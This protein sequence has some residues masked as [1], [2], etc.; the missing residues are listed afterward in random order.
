MSSYHRRSFLKT[1]LGFL[2]LSL[3]NPP[4]FLSAAAATNNSSRH[5]FDLLPQADETTG[6]HLL[7]LP[8]GFRYRSFGWTGDL[9]SDGSKTPDKHDGMAIL[10]EDEHKLVLCRNHELDGS[11]RAM[12]E[13]SRSYD[14]DAPAG[15]IN[16]VIDRDALSVTESF[17]SL[18]GTSRNCAGGL[19]GWQTWLSC[20]EVVADPGDTVDDFRYDC[21]REHGWVF[22]VGP[23]G[24]RSPTP[25]TA[26][27][28]FSHEAV[29]F[30]HRSGLFY[31]TEDQPTAGFYRFTP[32]KP[33]VLSQGGRLEMLAIE[34]AAD[35]RKGLPGSTEEGVKVHWV[36]IEDPERGHSPGRRDGLGVFD[37]GTRQGGATFA[38]LEGACFSNGKVYFCA[39]SGGRA[40]CGQI[41]EY[42]PVS[43]RLRIA[44]ESPHPDVLD[45]PDNLTV[46][47]QG[48]LL[49]CEDSDR[50]VQN[51]NLLDKEG[52]LRLFAQNNV[53][54]HGEKNGFTG[55][56]RTEEWAGPTFSADGQTLFINIQTP[57]ITFA[58]QGPWDQLT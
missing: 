57:G 26:M 7:R 29:V 49:I 5:T 34:G 40:E 24:N 31:L 4:R 37:Q 9:L 14:P 17:V 6:L 42:D 45:F 56:F 46:S 3:L 20:E 39:T 21:Q 30:D 22:E 23:K 27:G 18:S 19:T 12:G 2:G 28:R 32:R 58:I 47:P 35:L 15:C 8:E 16:L 43:E 10:F 38:R 51:L 41:W 11:G 55:D 52:Q 53:V 36:T 48:F 44:Y 54:L 1:G 33:G 50:G 25:L 13:A